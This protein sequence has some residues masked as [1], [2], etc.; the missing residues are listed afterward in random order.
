VHG[1]GG[2]RSPG[3]GVNGLAAILILGGPRVVALRNRLARTPDGA[4]AAGSA[5]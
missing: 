4:A 3:G 1:S 5:R 2:E